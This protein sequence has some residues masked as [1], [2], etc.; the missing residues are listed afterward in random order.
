MTHHAESTERLEQWRSVLSRAFVP[1][2]P[3]ALP[4]GSGAVTGSLRATELDGLQIAEVGGGGQ[5][6]RRTAAT[7]RAADPA[8]LK[9]GLQ[10]SGRGLLEQDGREAELRTGDFVLYDT[11]RP[12]RLRFD[13]AFRMLVVMCPRSALDL[14]SGVLRH[15]TAVPV[16]AREGLGMVVSPFISGLGRLLEAD[17]GGLSPGLGGGHLGAAVLDSLAAAFA[18]E[19]KGRTASAGSLRARAFA[20]I[21]AHLADPGLGPEAVAAALHVSVRYLQRAFEAEGETVAGWIRA[22]RLE[23][24]RRDLRNPGLDSR[25]VSAVAARWGL[26]NA[27]HFSRS[28][29]ATYGVSPREYR[30]GASLR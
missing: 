9:I 20:H 16:R 22:R 2:E 4:S 18:E 15:R 12:Y 30:H 23:R 27:A 6:V 17:G 11:T 7:I 28:F 24:C 26:V 14:P 19:A 21:E 10:V 8:H 1:L 29:R 5:L 25:S 13:T 3:S